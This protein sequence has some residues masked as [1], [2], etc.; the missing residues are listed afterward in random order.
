MI[1]TDPLPFEEALQSREIRSLLPTELRT[2]LL[3]TIPEQLRARSIFSAAVTQA[4]LLERGNQAVLKIAAGGSDRATQRVA[5]RELAV[6][7]GYQPPQGEE[8]TLADF[9]TSGRL[10]LFLDMNVQEMQEAGRYIQGQD[11]TILDQ[12]PAKELIRE[13]DSAEPR[14]WEQRFRDACEEVGD[15]LALAAFEASG[16]MV[17]RKDSRVWVALSRFDRPYAPYDFNSGMGDR[18]VDRDDAIDL[19]L[20]GR[21][22][23]VRPDDRDLNQDL[24]ATPA[25][26][27]ASLKAE[28]AEQLDGVAEFVDGILR[29]I[30]GPS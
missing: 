21:D 26:R 27:D 24:Q 17:A 29:L 28:L 4:E 10:N 23:Q 18:D 13:R 25:V 3:S 7:L 15:E 8:G 20:I 14:D 11:E 5:L 9:R 19:G 16:R 6:S 1:L 30:G 22:E 2:D 12:W